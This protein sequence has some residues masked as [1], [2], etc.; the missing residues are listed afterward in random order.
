[1]TDRRNLLTFGAIAVVY[2]CNSVFLRTFSFHLINQL[3]WTDTSVSVLQGTWGT[4]IVLL[5][6]LGGGVLS[7]RMGP[8]RLQNIVMLGLG[9]FLIAFGLM[10]SYWSRI[11]FATAGLV[12][13]SLADPCFSLAAMPLLMGLCRKG[14]EGSQF[15]TY[16]ELVNLCDVAG[17]YV[18]G[19]ALAWVSAPVLVFSCGMIVTATLLL[20]G[21]RLRE[22]GS[23][24]F[25]W[26]NK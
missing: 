19:H 22:R 3:H 21:L 12:F 23:V 9:G 10:A 17:A 15:T 5:V 4:G 11:P 20:V 16:M 8:R 14:V 26:L 6:I 7:D 18:S 24:R 1:M 2:F 25:S 13:S